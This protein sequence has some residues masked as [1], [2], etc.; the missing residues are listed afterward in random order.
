MKNIIENRWTKKIDDKIVTCCVFWIFE[1]GQRHKLRI[2]GYN[3]F[4]FF[5]K[6]EVFSSSKE[7]FEKWMVENGWKKKYILTDVLYRKTID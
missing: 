6:D 7:V 2:A 4:P 5:V 3:P 1:R